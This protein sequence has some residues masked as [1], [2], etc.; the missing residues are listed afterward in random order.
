M[1]RNQP[2][3]ARRGSKISGVHQL[4]RGLFRLE[5]IN[6]LLSGFL[7]EDVNKLAHW[8]LLTLTEMLDDIVAD[9][10]EGSAV[11]TEEYNELYYK[12][13]RRE[14][15]V[16]LATASTPQPTDGGAA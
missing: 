5:V 6:K 2:R 1:P 3:R 7:G 8:E 9:L 12:L 14:K 13:E 4:E 15:V 11:M 10:C 16:H